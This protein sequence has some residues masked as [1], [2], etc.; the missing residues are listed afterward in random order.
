MKLKIPG[1]RR[2][3]GNDIVREGDLEWP[4]SDPQISFL[5]SD[6]TIGAIPTIHVGCQMCTE[7]MRN[8][9]NDVW[10]KLPIKNAAV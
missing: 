2:L 6:G 9:G 3:G 1:W 5:F 7:E 8:Y 10:R 4:K